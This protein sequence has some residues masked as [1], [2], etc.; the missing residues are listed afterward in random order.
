MSHS[1]PAHGPALRPWQQ[2]I[3]VESRQ[4]VSLV[5]YEKSLPC[6]STLAALLHSVLRS[7]RSGSRRCWPTQRIILHLG[8]KRHIPAAAAHD[9][10]AAP[11][12]GAKLEKEWESSLADYESKYPEEAAEF[13]QLLTNDLPADWDVTLPTYTP[14]DKVC[15]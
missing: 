14:E 13:K 7:R 8:S 5:E 6:S 11:K 9:S 2:A 1:A 10:C 4:A 3:K 15:V 12:Q